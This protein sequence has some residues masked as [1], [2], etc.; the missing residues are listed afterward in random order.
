MSNNLHTKS[1]ELAI[2]FMEDVGIKKH[3][4]YISGEDLPVDG[5]G[6]KE[7]GLIPKVTVEWCPEEEANVND[8][9]G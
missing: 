6:L 1:V 3:I 5:I 9:Q 2:E 4:S 8:G 7:G